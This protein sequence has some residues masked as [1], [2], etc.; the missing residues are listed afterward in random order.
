VQGDPDHDLPLREDTRLLGRYLGDAVRT[1]N[2]DEIFESVERIRQTAV[3][4]RRADAQSAASVRPP[5]A[6]PRNQH[7]QAQTHTRL[8]AL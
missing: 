7:T 4:F 2:G 3:R 5:R 1:C 8:G 6:A